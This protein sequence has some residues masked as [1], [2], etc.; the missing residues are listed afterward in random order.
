MQADFPAIL[1]IQL[2]NFF[3]KVFYIYKD[4]K[5]YHATTKCSN[6]NANEDINKNSSSNT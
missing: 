1:I 3:L 2:S 5:Y 4:N 6:S